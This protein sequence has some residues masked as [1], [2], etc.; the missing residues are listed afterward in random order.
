MGQKS[1]RFVANVSP[2]VILNIN[3]SV[4]SS[5]CSRETFR[6]SPFFPASSIIKPGGGTVRYVTW[7]EQSNKIACPSLEG[8]PSYL[9]TNLERRFKRK[10]DFF[11][12]EL[13][14]H[15]AGGQFVAL[16]TSLD[17]DVIMCRRARA[18]IP[19]SIFRT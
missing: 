2:P 12:F 14:S 1:G 19:V 9:P 10:I 5:D 16:A 17:C 7:I 3:V 4:P 13:Q 11:F 15:V 6:V 18:F 8:L